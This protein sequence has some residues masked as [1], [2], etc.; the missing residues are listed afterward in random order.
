MEVVQQDDR[1]RPQPAFDV[2]DDRADARMWDVVPR[3]DV[4]EH[5][6]RPSFSEMSSVARECSAYGVRKSR[7]FQP[8]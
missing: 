7:G 5:L 1:S 3:I 8:T 4:P 6:E 2:A